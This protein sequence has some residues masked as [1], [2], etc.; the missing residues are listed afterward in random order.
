MSKLFKLKKWVTIQDAAKRL[1]ITFGEPVT[2]ADLFRLALDGHL[3]LSVYLVNAAYGRQC[4]PVK[5]EEIE[6]RE[7]P[8]LDGKSTIKLPEGGRV[9]AD[10]LGCFQVK[11][12]VQQMDSGLWDVPLSGGERIDVEFAYQQLT[13]GPEVTAVSLE[14]V[15]LSSTDGMLF[16]IQ[17]HYSDNE[18]FSKEDLK[19]P[20]L[21]RDNFHSAGALPNDV[22]FVIRTDVLMD[23]E[24][25]QDDVLNAVEN[26]LGTK[27]RNTLLT[28]IAALCK[29]AK[30]DHTKPAKTAGLIQSTADGM[31]LSI[32]EST[33]E[34]HLKKIPDAL[35][36]RMK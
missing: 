20:F 29:E 1:A 21:H 25:S 12:D 33:I 8:A 26:P 14:G 9:W 27:E 18:Y 24:K 32:G 2:E 11:R 34:G 4:V 16:E 19:K 36:T 28:I 3:K 6:W 30:L 23:F 13:N 10:E 5:F 17:T 31:G 35:G 15:L 7:V 22:V